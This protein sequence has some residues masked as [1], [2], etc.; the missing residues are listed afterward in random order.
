M[1]Q[2]SIKINNPCA[3]TILKFLNWSS[4]QVVNI[5]FVLLFKNKGDRKVNTK[6]YLAIIEIKDYNVMFDEQ[7]FFGQPVKNDLETW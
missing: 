3:R 5:L 6:Y 2:I 1:E 7:N 4:F